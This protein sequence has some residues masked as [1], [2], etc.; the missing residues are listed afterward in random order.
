M[1]YELG[2]DSLKS[3]NSGTDG[4]FFGDE[5]QSSVCL[6][7]RCQKTFVFK[8]CMKLPWR[9]QISGGLL[10]MNKFQRCFIVKVNCK[11]IVH[12]QFVHLMYYGPNLL[13]IT[14]TVLISR[15]LKPL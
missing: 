11:E 2:T 8:S 9:L 6:T 3:M 4:P 1:S 7:L 13:Y 14:F 12:V 10:P 15:H 5:D